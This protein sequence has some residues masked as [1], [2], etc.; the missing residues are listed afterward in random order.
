[1]NLILIYPEDEATNDEPRRVV[2]TG[3]RATH[4]REVLR[5]VVGQSVRV[6]MLDGPVGT[7]VVSEISDTS[8]GLE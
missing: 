2:L 5:A 7:A 8:V 1:M 4:V 6:G 3:A